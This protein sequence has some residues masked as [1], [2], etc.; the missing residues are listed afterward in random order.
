MFRHLLPAAVLLLAGAPLAAQTDSDAALRRIVPGSPVPAGFIADMADVVPPEAEADINGRIAAMQSAGRGDVGVAVLPS[1]GDF[2][3][4]EV[5]VAI[6]RDWKIGSVADIGSA[7]RDLGALLLIVPKEL[8][9]DNRGH[10]WITTGRG[11]EGILTDAAAGAVCRDR[12]VPRLREQDYGGAITAGVAAIDSI[13]S[14]D[15]FLAAGETAGG[16]GRGGP[17]A[18][19][20]LAIVL[21]FIGTIAGSVAAF[22]GIRRHRRN[23]PRTCPTC[24][25]EMHRVDEAGDDAFLGHGERVEE[26]VKSVDYDVWVCGACGTQR[27]ERYARWMT[28]Y[29]E[30]SECGAKTA[31]TR[32]RVVEAATTASSGVAEDTTTCEACSHQKVEKV[33][34]PK[35][36]ASSGGGSGGG[37]GGGGASFGGSGAT[38]GGGAGSS[39]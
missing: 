37:G 31:R 14:G 34:L 33:V 38:S 21:G 5:G 13:L 19:T 16:G 20:V 35:V 36:T 15:A 29:K 26:R 11:A 3:P 1:I 12:V 9:P 22:F 10:C 30:C 25:R 32:R 23:R 7:Q 39:Y 8:A 28:A 24:R 2:Q 17:G 6:Y 4:Y 18:G 27:P